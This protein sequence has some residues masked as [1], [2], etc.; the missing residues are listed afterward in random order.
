MPSVQPTAT[1]YDVGER[2]VDR[3]RHALTFTQATERAL[4]EALELLERTRE[5]ANDDA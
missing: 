4:Q 1:N 3:I 2:L 5:E